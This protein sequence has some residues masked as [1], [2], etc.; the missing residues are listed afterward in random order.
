[1]VAVCSGCNVF[2]M[3]T[4]CV[5]GILGGFGYLAVHVIMLKCK[6]DDPLDAVAV[7]G[8]GGEGLFLQSLLYER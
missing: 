7:H 6:F 2:H 3:W 1:M 5:A 4:G 8:G